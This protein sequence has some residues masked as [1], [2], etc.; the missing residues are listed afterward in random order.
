[1]VH[2]QKQE[3]KQSVHIHF[4]GDTP[5]KKK[6]ASKKK[7]STRRTKREL[8]PEKIISPQ[9]QY[10]IP[11]PILNNYPQVAHQT[12]QAIQN[13]LRQALSNPTRNSV[14]NPIAPTIP[15]NID[16]TPNRAV[17]NV[18]K[19]FEGVSQIDETEPI[20]DTASEVESDITELGS[21]MPF[22]G[23]NDPLPSELMIS[24]D[25]SSTKHEPTFKPKTTTTSSLGADSIT[26]YHS[27]SIFNKLYEDTRK[28][29]REIQEEIRHGGVLEH[30][31]NEKHVEQ[32]GLLKERAKEFDD[33]YIKR[34]EEEAERAGEAGEAEQTR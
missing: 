31:I 26:T 18:T 30:D 28:E 32:Y 9:I 14:F 1:M 29:L 21:Q 22:Q 5:T 16:N 6:R 27:D 7:K 23:D 15:S 33:S 4:H 8:L 10:R 13:E 17:A 20:N 19:R 3:Q 24:D 2:K 12:Q 11:Q 25:E 34:F